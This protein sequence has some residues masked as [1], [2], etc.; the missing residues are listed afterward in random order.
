MRLL[1]TVLLVTS[2]LFLAAANL[3][4]SA[5]RSTIPLALNDQVN[6]IEVRREKHPGKDDVYLLTLR[7]GQILQ[8]DRPVA[9]AININHSIQKE[10]WARTLQI[11][12]KVLNLG[13][14]ADFHGMIRAMPGTLLV[15]IATAIW[16]LVARST[17][18]SPQSR[19]RTTD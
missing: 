10:A 11:D 3:W 2:A 18:N 17:M 5:A 15:V 14:S 16:V 8:V 19:H 12:S 6:K 13:W 7:S 4:Y 9:D 1:N